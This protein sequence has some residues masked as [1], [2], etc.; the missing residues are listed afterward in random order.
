M[1]GSILAILVFVLIIVIF[2][3]ILWKFVLYKFPFIQAIGKSAFKKTY[4]VVFF[5]RNQSFAKFCNDW[6]PGVKFLVWKA[7][8]KLKPNSLDNYLN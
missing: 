6:C 7:G 3:T 1:I 5:K 2:W 8:Y 4:D